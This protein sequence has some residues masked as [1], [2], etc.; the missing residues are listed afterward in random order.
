MNQPLS[1]LR[2]AS[3]DINQLL[4]IQF[5]II[6]MIN[7]PRMQSHYQFLCHWLDNISCL[8]GLFYLFYFNLFLYNNYLMY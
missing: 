5:F 3:S 6:S 8:M 7:Y 4:V 2:E 1:F